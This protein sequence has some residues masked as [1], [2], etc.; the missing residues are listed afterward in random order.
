MLP[1][2]SLSDPDRREKASDAELLAAITRDLRA[3]YSDIIREPLPDS[4]AA[5]LRRLESRAAP[6]APA[7]ERGK[8]QVA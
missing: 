4:L 8:F 6:P 7:P 2:R 1:N 3:I 5:A